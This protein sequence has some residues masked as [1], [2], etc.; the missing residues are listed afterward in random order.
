MPF[1]Q[2]TLRG[3]GL[4]LRPMA[5]ADRVPLGWAAADPFIWAQH[6]EPD[7]WTPE[8]FA[9]YFDGGLASRGAL[10]VAEADGGRLIGSSRYAA[11]D[12]D[13]RRVEIGWTF[14]IRELWGGPT[15]RA[16]KRL[17]LDHAFHHVDA[18]VF[19][20]GAANLRS[21]R[22]VEKIGARLDGAAPYDHVVYRLDASDW[23]ARA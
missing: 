14:L 19:R 5:E 8:G 11:H 12:P 13:A 20:I 9:R 17:M 6:P 7:R 15:N 3:S 4:I 18:V 1:R 16:V 21:R 22:A 10:V 2:P 23:A